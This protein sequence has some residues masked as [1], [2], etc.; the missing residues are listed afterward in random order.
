MF[1][2]GGSKPSDVITCPKQ[3]DSLNNLRVI[4]TQKVFYIQ[5]VN[6]LNVLTKGC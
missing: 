3:I 1:S 4:Q 6:D 2:A 5:H